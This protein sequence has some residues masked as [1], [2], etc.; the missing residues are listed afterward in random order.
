MTPG[1]T[2]IRLWNKPP[3]AYGL[4]DEPT[5]W[6][7]LIPP[8]VSFVFHLLLCFVLLADC[9]PLC[10]RLYHFF[11][12]IFSLSHIKHSGCR[13]ISN[14]DTSPTM[15]LTHT[16]T[17]TSCT[18]PSLLSL[19][20]LCLYQPTTSLWHYTD[21]SPSL[22]YLPTSYPLTSPSPTFSVFV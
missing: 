8:P 15:Q 9:L 11:L 2:F 16:H 1:C 6:A 17:H 18:L 12:I 4:P 10:S 19:S 7:S 22:C 13:N 3:W 14:W 21:V 20:S 5:C